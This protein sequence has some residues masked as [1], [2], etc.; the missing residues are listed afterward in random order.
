[1]G[2]KLWSAAEEKYF[3]REIVPRSGRRAA[4]DRANEELPWSQLAVIM[5]EAMDKQ[6]TAQREY[7]G[8]VMCK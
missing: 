5:Q 7:T 2:G 8:Q 1:M 4:I 6:G 3:W